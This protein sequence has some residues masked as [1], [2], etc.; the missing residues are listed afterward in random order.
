MAR[1]RGQ[2]WEAAAFG[3]IAQKEVKWKD[4]AAR[5]VMMME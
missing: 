2:V 4:R 1:G 3:T 5:V